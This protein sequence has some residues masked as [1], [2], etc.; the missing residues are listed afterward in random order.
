M[1]K[2]RT[3]CAAFYGEGVQG[4]GKG[5]HGVGYLAVYPTPGYLTSTPEPQK[6]RVCILLECFRF[7][8][9]FSGGGY[10]CKN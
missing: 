1:G 2:K 4:E 3:R 6:Q 7:S 10:H 5:M 8:K 9:G